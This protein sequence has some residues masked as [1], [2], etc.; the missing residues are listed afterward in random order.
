MDALSFIKKQF[1]I[2]DKAKGPY[3]ID[4]LSREGLYDVF[5]NLGLKTGVEVGVYRGAN[6]LEMLKRMPKLELTGVDFY[7]GY[8]RKRTRRTQ[9]GFLRTAKRTLA[10]HLDSGRFKFLRRSSMDAVRKIEDESL[11]FVYIDA[12]HNFDFVMQ[13]IIEWS[14]K[15]RK[16]GVVSGHDYYR[17]EKMRGVVLAVNVYTKAHKIKPWFVTCEPRKR[18]WFWIK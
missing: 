8:S 7:R 17:H 11:D 6:A 3:E 10:E 12:N 4:G 18:S 16:G 14:K 15:V 9:R 2:P 13:D 5:A 1:K